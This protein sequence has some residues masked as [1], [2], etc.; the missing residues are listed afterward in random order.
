[1]I[2]KIQAAFEDGFSL[3]ALVEAITILVKEILAYVAGEEGYAY[4]AE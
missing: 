1:M 3:A 4:P 2:E